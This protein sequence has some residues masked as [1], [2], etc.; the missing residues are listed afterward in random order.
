MGLL[1][2]IYSEFKRKIK[3]SVDFRNA[4]KRLLSSVD[5]TDQEKDVLQRVSLSIDKAD[6]MYAGNAFHY[7]RVGLSALRCIREALQ[8]NSNEVD[9]EYVMDFPSGYG[10]VLRFLKAMFPNAVI[11][12][13]EIDS[14]AL[15]FCRKNFSVQ[16]FLSTKNFSDYPFPTN[17][18]WF[19]G[20]LFTHINEQSSRE[21][22]KLFSSHL[23]DY[24]ISAMT[25]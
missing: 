12:G 24:G 4:K 8:S 3:V 9:V 14:D 21:L 15:H 5:Y 23:S 25:Y 6:I 7:L 18:T 16:S 17:M 22:L 13:A 19:G 11:T 2:E 10:R 1:T 20:S